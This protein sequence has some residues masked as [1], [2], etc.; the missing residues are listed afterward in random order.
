MVLA[1]LGVLWGLSSVA[2]TAWLGPTR[3]NN[4][5]DHLASALEHSQLLAMRDLRSYRVR[6][7]AQNLNLESKVGST[8]RRE[9]TWDQLPSGVTVTATRWPSFSAHGFAVGGTLTLRD[10]E[11]QTQEIRVSPSGRIAVLR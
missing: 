1:V 2:N 10:A 11:S 3:L 4:A 9:M 7:E 5:T 8:W 6:L